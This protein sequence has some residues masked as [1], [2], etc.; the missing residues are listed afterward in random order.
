MPT[1]HQQAE[2]RTPEGGQLGCKSQGPHVLDDVFTSMV[3]QAVHTG[4]SSIFPVGCEEMHVRL[5][6]HPKPPK[7]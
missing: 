1:D 2:G 4:E 5:T 3:V 6:L 7:P